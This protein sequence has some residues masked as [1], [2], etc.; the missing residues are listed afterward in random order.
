MLSQNQHAVID[1]VQSK[2]NV[3]ITGPGGV[4]KSTIIRHIVSDA[5]FQAD[6]IGVTAMTGSAAVLIGGRT[7]HS[8]L[9][10]GLG[11]D[12]AIDLAQ[13]I[14]SNRKTLAVWRS[15]S[16][17]IIDEISMMSGQLLDKLNQVAK[18]VT[19]RKKPFGGIRLVLSGDFLQLPCI[20]GSFAFEA[21]CWNELYLEI[22]DLIEIHRQPDQIFKDFLAMA[23]V[24]K[25]TASDL[26]RVV[27]SSSP[28]NDGI[29]PTK[30]LCK[31]YDVDRINNSELLKLANETNTFEIEIEKRSPRCP[32][33]VKWE[34]Y[35]NAPQMLTLSIGAQVM[36][37]I[38]M[39]A[40]SVLVNGSR[41]VVVGFNP[42]DLPIV[43]FESTTQTI[44][45]YEWEVYEEKCLLAVIYQIPLRL[46]WAITV[47]K[48]QGLTVD[49]AVINLSGVFECG[50]AYVALSRVKCAKSLTL[51]NA[52]PN[53]FKAHP[54]AIQFYENLRTGDPTIKLEKFTF[55]FSGPFSQWHPCK[56]SV[57][58]IDY[59]CAEQYMM[60]QKAKLFNDSSSLEKIL[61][62]D[63]PSRQKQLGR[64]VCNF[65]KLV[66]DGACQDVVYTGNVSKFTQNLY[67]MEKLLATKPAL[68]VESSVADTIW[69][70]GLS[71]TDPNRFDR[72][73]WLGRNLLGEILTKIRDNI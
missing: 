64:T 51:L 55:F 25:A 24:G 26:D 32:H 4:G 20:T 46:A 50:Q 66:W 42:D 17:L 29:I 39:P 13:K 34:K 28:S 49:S 52:S 19:G 9:G 30:I 38:N 14:R 1:S 23:R 60:A 11:R 36:L 67:L 18:L 16:I 6:V 57:G 44:V 12:S 2:R 72:S 59:N 56:F 43:K 21:T 5:Q 3:F 69:A 37:L 54:K 58:G 8:Y 48:S 63:N 70:N 27:K 73:K 65:D 33:D 22:F 61:A 7:L 10:I 68:L 41:G 47:H 35:C 31:N 62:T 71:K 40:P 15:T 45:H 53:S